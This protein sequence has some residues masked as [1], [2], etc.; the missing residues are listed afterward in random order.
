MSEITWFDWSKTA[1]Q[2]SVNSH[3]KFLCQYQASRQASAQPGVF[4]SQ[5]FRYFP[6]FEVAILVKYTVLLVLG[7]C[8][9][10]SKE[11][12]FIFT[13]VWPYRFHVSW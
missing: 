9:M 4:L 2:F 8:V 11:V 10:A 3:G 12:I 5:D 7:K 6:A 13:E 1:K